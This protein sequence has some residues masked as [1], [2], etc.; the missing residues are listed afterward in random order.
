[1]ARG[2]ETYRHTHNRIRDKQL[3]LPVQHT[4]PL[5]MA[6][7]L[8]YR[9]TRNHLLRPFEKPPNALAVVSA[10][11]RRIIPRDEHGTP[12]LPRP[13]QMRGVKMRMADHNR[14]QPALLVDKI[15]SCLVEKRNQVPENVAM[16]RLEQDS[17]LAYT[18][19]LARGSRVGKAG[20]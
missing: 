16:G 4:T 19:L 13:L 1:M 17:A 3:P 11:P 12:E 6:P 9:H 5:E 14:L 10:E 18:Q 20:G 7:A 15:N 8:D 2:R